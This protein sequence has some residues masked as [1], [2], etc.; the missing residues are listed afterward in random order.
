M[1]WSFYDRV[2][3][4]LALSKLYFGPIEGLGIRHCHICI[5]YVALF[6]VIIAVYTHV[7]PHATVFLKWTDFIKSC[8]VEKYQKA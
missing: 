3:N 6:H 4:I 8:F 5:Y 2:Q 1:P 7:L